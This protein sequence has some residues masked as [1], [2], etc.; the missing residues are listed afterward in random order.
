VITP[1]AVIMVVAPVCSSGVVHAPTLPVIMHARTTAVNLG[2]V[3]GARVHDH[4]HETPDERVGGSW[5]WHRE[6]V[7]RKWTYPQAG[8][9]ENLGGTGRAVLPRSPVQV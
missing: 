9:F 7:A 1:S 3:G 5:R 6:L 8:T 4:R 2:G